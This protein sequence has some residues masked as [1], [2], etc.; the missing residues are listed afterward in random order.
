MKEVILILADLVNNIHD[1]IIQITKS[2]GWNLTDKD[3]HLW[4][5]GIMGFV[6]FICCHLVFSYLAKWS[7]TA[8]SFIYTLTIL[9]ILA[10]AVE[11]QQKVTNRG[12][13]DFADAVIGVWGFTLFFALYIFIKYSIHLIKQ[14]LRKYKSKR[15]IN[16]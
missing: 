10:F 8:I 13:M 15:S 11:I 2:L 12:N 9:I 7:I 6:L 3:L 5:F 16:T 4:I 14:M 1:A